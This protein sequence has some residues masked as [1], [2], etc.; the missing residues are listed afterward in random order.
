MDTWQRRLEDVR[1]LESKA[2]L[3]CNRK[4]VTVAYNALA[5]WHR[6]VGLALAEREVR[7]SDEEKLL[8][9]VFG[10]WVRGRYAN[11]PS[12]VNTGCFD[13]HEIAGD[14]VGSRTRSM[15]AS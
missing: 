8:R 14:F 6:R 7:K 1:Q 9:T 5:R 4:R 15:S 11:V 12:G 13:L 10:Q 3:I 2:D